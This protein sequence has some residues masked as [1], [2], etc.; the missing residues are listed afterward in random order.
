MHKEIDAYERPD[1][2]RYYDQVLS[3]SSCEGYGTSAAENEAYVDP[4]ECA[5]L[6]VPMSYDDPGGETMQ[7]AVL[8]LPAQGGAGQRIGSLVINP[9]GPGGSGMKEAVQVSDTF[10]ASPVVQQL[11]VVGFDPRHRLLH[12]RGT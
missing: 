12:R 2:R 11:D 10:A 8:R 5:R 7:V 9:G 4:F 6:E 1:L 3:F